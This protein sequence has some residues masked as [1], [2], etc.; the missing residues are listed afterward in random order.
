M[1]NQ[2]VRIKDHLGQ[3]QLEM[4][5]KRFGRLLVISY[6]T[7]V[8]MQACCSWYLCRCDCGTEKVIQGNRLRTGNTKSCGCL[9]R[10]IVAKHCQKLGSR[11]GESSNS[12]YHGFC[13]GIR[14]FRQIVRARDK[15]C[16]YD[17]DNECKG[18]LEVHH[19]DGDHDNNSLENG[20]LLCH[21]HHTIVT[22]GSNIWR[23]KCLSVR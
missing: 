16:Q 13:V 19:L 22:Y 4:I 5:G 20:S 14:K 21:S 8:S 7:D 15:V 10:E 12:Y 6:N 17:E 3:K 18:Q 9:H 2:Y 11:T 23:P 1:P